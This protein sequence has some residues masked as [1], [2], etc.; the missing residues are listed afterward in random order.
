MAPS[1]NF[2]VPMLLAIYKGGGSPAQPGRIGV[3]E[4]VPEDV[5]DKVII[6]AVQYQQM[7]LATKITLVDSIFTTMANSTTP[8]AAQIEESVEQQVPH[9]VHDEPSSVRNYRQVPYNTPPSTT[10]RKQA[11]ANSMSELM[12]DPE[13]PIKQSRKRK[14]V[15]ARGDLDDTQISNRVL[16]AGKDDTFVGRIFR[17]PNGNW[18]DEF[19]TLPETTNN[20]IERKIYDDYRRNPE[21]DRRWKII[22]RDKKAHLQ[23]GRCANNII[24]ER[25]TEPRPY[26]AVGCNKQRSCGHCIETKRICVRPLTQ[27]G[28][29]EMTIL[30]LPE[31]LRIGKK[32]EDIEFWVKGTEA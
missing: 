12:E 11:E 26:G 13:D 28:D 32:P 29:T 20:M 31:S 21:H 8:D 10:S 17:Q 5:L 23:S 19:G 2:M 4:T 14:R 7:T 6:D 25:R 27:D 1:E 30:P 22:V 3:L 16:P 18:S 24:Y 9:I 15:A